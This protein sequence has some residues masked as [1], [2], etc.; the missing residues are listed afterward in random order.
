LKDNC[1]GSLQTEAQIGNP[2]VQTQ[3]C[4][5][6]NEDV[7]RVRCARERL[8]QRACLETAQTPQREVLAL[9]QN[10]G[11]AARKPA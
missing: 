1:R 8:R 10:S 5:V 4:H 7:V 9:A 6:A 3:H 2:Q 11:A